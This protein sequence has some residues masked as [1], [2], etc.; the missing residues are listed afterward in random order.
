MRYGASATIVRVRGE[1]D[2]SSSELLRR[3]ITRAFGRSRGIIVDL[4]SVTY[5]DGSG[6]R[7]LNGAARAAGGARGGLR[8][9]GQ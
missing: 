4:G 3:C 1:V 6:F 5:L 2:L 7:V 9:P 8:V